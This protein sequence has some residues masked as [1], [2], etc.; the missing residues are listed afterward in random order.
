[1]NCSWRLV[2]TMGCA[3][4]LSAGAMAGELISSFET[5]ESVAQFKPG[6]VV[7]ERVQEHATEGKWSLRVQFAGSEKD[8]WP[9]ISYLPAN[10]NLLRDKVLAFDVFNPQE[11]RVSLSYRIDDGHG[12]KLFDGAGLAAQAHTTVEIWTSGLKN[13]LDLTNITKVYPYIRMPRRDY[14]L[15]FDNFR[16][17]E[18]SQRFKPM[19]YLEMAAPVQ[20]IEADE[21]RGYVLFHRHYLDLV[22]PTSLPRPEETEFD[23]RV[24]ATP[25]EHEPVTVSVHA[26]RDLGDVRVS[27]SGL[28]SPEGGLIPAEAVTVYP[29][30][31]LHKRLTYPSEY[32]VEDMPVLLERRESAEVPAGESKRFWLDIRVPEDATPG[33]Y[34]A[35]VSVNA[36][37]G[38][39]SELPLALRV[40]PF[41]LSDPNGILWGEYYTGPRMDREAPAYKQVMLAELADM[42]D[43][44][45]TSVGL[46]FGPSLEA[47][48][49]T[50]DGVEVAYDE[51]E[52][53]AWFMDA[54]VQLG[55][56][57][58]II[59]LA[60]TP[61]SLLGGDYALNS[62]E[63]ARLYQAAWMVMKAEAVRRG[64]PEVIVQPVDEPGWGDQA[65]KDR[66]VRLLKLLKEIPE[67]LTEQD[68]PADEFFEEIAGPYADVWN[69]NGGV[70]EPERVAQ[71]IGDGHIVTCYNND[72]EC[73]RPE[74]GR[75]AAGFYLFA[76][77]TRG[78]YNWQY[79]GWKGDPYNDQDAQHGDFLHVYPETDDEV[80]GPATGW[81]GFREGT[82]DFKYCD[83]L[84][85]AIVRA[86]EAGKRE[87]AEAAAQVL[88]DLVD[89]IDYKP[90]IRHTARWEEVTT[91]QDGVRRISGQMQ[92]PNGWEFEDYDKARWQVVEQIIRLKRAIGEIAQAPDAAGEVGKGG[93]GGGPLLSGVRWQDL[94][95]VAEGP[96]LGGRVQ[97]SIPRL[98]AAP[99]LDG[100]L[101]DPAWRGAATTAPWMRST[102]DGE[103]PVQTRAL[104]GI[105]E[106]RLYLGFECQEPTT[107]GVVARV[108]EDGGSVW[109][110]DCVEMFF[111]GNLDQATFRQVVIN[112][113]G[114]VGTVSHGVGD[115]APV[116]QR[117]ARVGEGAWYAELSVPVAELG[118]TG[119]TFG[120]NLCR[121]RR[122]SG[123]LELSCWSPTGGGFSQPERFGLATMSTLYIASFKLG[124][125]LLGRNELT[126]ELVN[127][128]AAARSIKL[129]LCWWQGEGVRL[130]R[131][132]RVF[133]LEPGQRLKARLP[134]DI[135]RY[136]VPVELRLAVL[137]GAGQVL[138]EHEFAQRVPP[139]MVTR[140]RPRLFFLEE[141][142]AGL[143]ARFRLSEE[144][145]RRGQ[146]VVAIFT[147]PEMMLV[148]RQEIEPIE[149]TLVSARLNIGGLPE[150]RYSVHIVLKK[151]EGETLVRV[152][153][154]REMIRKIPGPFS[155]RQA[156]DKGQ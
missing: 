133:A 45:M 15:Y 93:N 60:D 110:D 100:H 148:A 149:A 34:E 150:G 10:P 144:L 29:V 30:R 120:L 83:L 130:E 54:F 137:D 12:Q 155:S 64:W 18:A 123:G 9:G 59:Q 156:M 36:Q 4:A 72:V 125:G 114:T 77:G 13:D 154:A 113:L 19:R 104:L 69:Y 24:F 132:S 108:T 5:E 146:L 76:S 88:A 26:L 21:A 25:G 63:F 139:P 68:G 40:V 41:T 143:Q 65:K 7:M 112:S 79:H 135:T 55:F 101:G 38:Q 109:T 58:P 48:E 32:Y 98:P 91:E 118:L 81:E 61:Q 71:A 1:M 73:Y 147:E 96:S 23:L 122:A 126:V 33:I 103:A 20:P 121:E 35:T 85:K 136:D 82:D 107:E 43:H 27:V 115:W 37:G 153:E 141:D 89:S 124:E 106:E 56:P 138:A 2:L 95:G 11:D 117:A 152:A 74:M 86:R 6:Q 51:A 14:V 151:R 142:C 53:Y 80:G 50:D 42:R 31:C 128:E 75:Y 119:T 129:R 102:G 57:A 145:Q 8:T 67:M 44:G 46:C 131:E 70:G 78:I 49:I 39:S 140:V 3:A 97:V 22:F 52:R 17:A 66:T 47:F 62:D 111:D 127:E 94:D 116:V 84:A 92:V 16:Y 90:R 134:Y 105:F 87:Q 99:K 28:K